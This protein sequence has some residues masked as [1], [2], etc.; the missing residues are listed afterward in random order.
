MNA[1]AK[2]PE[3]YGAHDLDAE[4]RIVLIGTL[5]RGFRTPADAVN[6]LVSAGYSWGE[7]GGREASIAIQREIERQRR[8]GERARIET[9][10]IGENRW[11]ARS[12]DYL[13]LIGDG[14]TDFAAVM[15]LVK[16]MDQAND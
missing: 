5:L 6:R 15:D 12:A 3:V 7:I 1:P 13:T 10:Q 8:D 4:I 14:G 2:F 11:I 9:T 16:K